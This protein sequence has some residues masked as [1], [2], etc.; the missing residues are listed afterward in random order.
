MRIN[1]DATTL[2]LPSAGIKTYMHYWLGSLAEAASHR[3][4]NIGVYPP[5]LQPSSVIEHGSQRNSAGDFLR[6]KFVQLANTRHSPL[7]DFLSSGVDLFHCSQHIRRPPRGP[8]VTATIFDF[9]CWTKPEYHTADNVAATKRYADQILRKCDGLIAI[10]SHARD[11]AAEILGISKDR[12]RVIYPGI[13]DAFFEVSQEQAS[14]IRSKYELPATY[15]LFVGCIEP[16]KNI[17][18]L[19]RAYR[20]LPENI[21]REAP[22]ILAGPFGWKSEEVRNHIGTRD[23]RY[24]DYV[25]EP[26]LPGLFRGAAALVY[27]SFYEGFGLPV[28]QA[29]AAGVPVITSDRSSLPEVA[30][31]GALTVDP[32]STDAL[33]AAMERILT[34]PEVGRTLGKKGR[35]RAQL[36][37]WPACAEDSLDYFHEVRERIGR[38]G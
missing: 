13:A 7:V 8:A 2:L 1:I 16:R 33:A 15:L 9:S 26:D 19:I 31:D 29:M 20:C 38:R 6:L 14:G 17:L 32:D 18:G 34:N 35:E 10:S 21:R 25:P 37:R 36:F 12:I 4:D 22:L 24:L 28:A 23:V 30:G 5:T 27:P 11:D 3:G